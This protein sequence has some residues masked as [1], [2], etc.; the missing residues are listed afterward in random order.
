MATPAAYGNS[1]A[2]G[3]SGAAALAYAMATAI[4]PRLHL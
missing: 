3:P 2:R 1:Q 4:P